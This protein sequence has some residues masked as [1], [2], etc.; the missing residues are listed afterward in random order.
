LETILSEA[1]I[2]TSVLSA[3][4]YRKLLAIQ[5]LMANNTVVQNRQFVSLI[6][7]KRDV[8]LNIIC[9]AVIRNSFDLLII[10]PRGR[11]Y[12]EN[13]IGPKTK[14]WGTP[15]DKAAVADM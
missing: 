14:P 9:V 8:Q 5:S 12:K 2:R 6:W 4:S 7:L 3:L 10:S 15:Q 11:I 13:K 1:I